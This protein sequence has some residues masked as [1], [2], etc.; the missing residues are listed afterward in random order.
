MEC[1]SCRVGGMQFP[2]RARPPEASLAKQMGKRSGVPV[3]IASFSGLILIALFWLIYFK[4][5]VGEGMQLPWLPTFNAACNALSLVLMLLGLYCVGIGRRVAHAT[6]MILALLASASFL[7][8]YLVHHWLHGDTRF[9]RQDWLRLVYFPLLISHVLASMV[10]LP[11]ILTTVY[12]AARSQWV[13]HVRIARWTWPIWCYV[14]LTGILVYC[15][16][17]FLNP[18]P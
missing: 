11:L 16:L 14:S 4:D 13:A 8:G 12:R 5:P 2:S 6:A 1:L 17:R 15:F 3:A 10:A 7:G 18:Q 9:L